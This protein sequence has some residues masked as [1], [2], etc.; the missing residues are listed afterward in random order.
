MLFFSWLTTTVR[1]FAHM[2]TSSPKVAPPPPPPVALPPIEP[3]SLSSSIRSEQR[4]GRSLELRSRAEHADMS[5]DHRRSEARVSSDLESGEFRGNLSNVTG[6]V[7]AHAPEGRVWD[8]ASEEFIL[9]VRRKCEVCS[10]QCSEAALFHRRMHGRLAIPG[11][12]IPILMSPVSQLNECEAGVWVKH[13]NTGVFVVLS[14]LSAIQTYFDFSRRS[15]RYMHSSHKYNELI[16]DIDI[17]LSKP[18]EFRSNVHTLTM[19]WKQALTSLNK[20]NWWVTTSGPDKL[21]R[22]WG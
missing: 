14:V 7:A 15:E 9:N 8:K 18:V 12:I 2:L 10:R 11:V 13:T 17:E 21:F 4:D 20:T 3:L 19:R 6:A 5:G 1:T 22:G 16:G